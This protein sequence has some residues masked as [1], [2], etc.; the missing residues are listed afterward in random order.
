[1]GLWLPFFVF[2]A[3]SIAMFVRAARRVPDPRLGIWLD[4][5]FDRLGRFLPKRRSPAPTRA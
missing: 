2:T 5:Q 3:I 4:R 1:L